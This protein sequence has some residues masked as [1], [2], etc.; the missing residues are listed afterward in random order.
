MAKAHDVRHELNEKGDPEDTEG[1]QERSNKGAIGFVAGLVPLARH[2]VGQEKEI[3]DER[4]TVQR[5]GS[6]TF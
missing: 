3:D 6:E 4:D 5:A 1:Q 2:H